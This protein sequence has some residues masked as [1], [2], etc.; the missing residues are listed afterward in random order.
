MVAGVIGLIDYVAFYGKIYPGVYVGE[1]DLGGKTVE[2][3]E[4]L[5]NDTY[6]ERL[7]RNDVVIYVNDEAQAAGV[8]DEGA[9]GIAEELSVE[10]AKQTVQY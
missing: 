7:N 10:Q 3:A 5:I 6:S 1:V 8:Q 9:S 2:E 4:T